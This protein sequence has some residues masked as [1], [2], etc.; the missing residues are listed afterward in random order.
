[1][2]LVTVASSASEAQQF[3]ESVSIKPIPPEKCIGGK[4]VNWLVVE[5]V[6]VVRAQKVRHVHISNVG[7]RALSAEERSEDARVHATEI[8]LVELDR[9][10]RESAGTGKVTKTP[11]RRPHENPRVTHGYILTN[12]IEARRVFEELEVLNL[13]AQLG[14]HGVTDGRRRGGHE[15]AESRIRPIDNLRKGVGDLFGDAETA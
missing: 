9:P 11:T 1:V 5:D 8:G 10:Q 2:E 4:S 13:V 6:G 12:H 7:S 3:L 14:G 15:G